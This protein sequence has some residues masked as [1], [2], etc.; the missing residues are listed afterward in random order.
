MTLRVCVADCVCAMSSHHIFSYFYLPV[1][2]NLHHWSNIFFYSIMIRAYIS[3]F[4][5]FEVLVVVAAAVCKNGII[6]IIIWQFRAHSIQSHKSINIRVELV[7]E[8]ANYVDE[9]TLC[10]L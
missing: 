8:S 3:A 6:F 4:T 5:I 1:S 7:E 10:L 2:V 9:H